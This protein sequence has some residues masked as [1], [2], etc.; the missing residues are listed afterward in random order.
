MSQCDFTFDLTHVV[1]IAGSSSGAEA[2]KLSNFLVD[3]LVMSP[4]HA[5]A[6]LQVLTRNVAQWEKNWGLI[7]VSIPEPPSG[8]ESAT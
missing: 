7:E 3:R 8:E 4:Q 6:F 5:K 1:P 2:P